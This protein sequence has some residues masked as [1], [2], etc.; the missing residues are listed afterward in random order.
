MGKNKELAKN[1]LIISVGKLCTQFLTFLLLPLYT[2]L[3][4]TEEFG[5]VD[6][7]S[8]YVQLLLPIAFLQIDQALLRFIID[9]RSDR[10]KISVQ[11]TCVSVFVLI[12][13]TILTVLFLVIQSC[14]NIDYFLYLYLTLIVTCLS[15]IGL[16]I[17]RGMGDNIT[18]SFSSFLCGATT[19]ILN[20][21]FIAVFHMKTEG[22]LLSVIIGNIITFIYILFKIRIYKYFSFVKYN[23]EILKKMLLYALPLVPNALI[24]W[25]VNASD[26]SMVLCFLGASYNGIL[27]I[28]HKFPTLITTFYNI[29][30][31]SWVESASLHLKE[32][33][34][35]TFFTGVF[36]TVYR[37][38]FSMTI[39]L[40]CV[41]PFVFNIFI[42]ENYN[43]AFYQIP[44]YAGASFFNV[45]VG[46]YSVIYISEMKT[47]EIAKT[48]FYSGAINLIINFLLITKIGLYAASISSFLAFG[49]MA[50]YR[51]ID[52]RKYIKQTIDYKLMFSSVVLF[53]ATII[54]YYTEM[55]YLQIL[56]L[57]IVLIYS[58]VLNRKIINTVLDRILKWRVE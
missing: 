26:R 34:R 17:A 20:V 30:H 47:G 8:T 48:S 1:T 2:A 14:L 10:E 33:D 41:M 35:D 4:S 53:I 57:A 49:A 15:S 38:F 51:A 27:A 5:A 45:I 56:F 50:V 32:E 11:I 22:M 29:F 23:F 3:L 16:Q 46:L 40:I 54:V 42:N 6:I 19:V 43:A 39:C 13:T 21:V 58:F 36:D 37:L 18:Y 28:A 7:V 31:I 25:I 24:W 52:T 9:N 44:V 55:K 12:Q